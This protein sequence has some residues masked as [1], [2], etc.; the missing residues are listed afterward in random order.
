MSAA[1]SLPLD[2]AFVTEVDPNAWWRLVKQRA[3]GL[4]SQLSVSG[5][6][7]AIAAAVGLGIGYLTNVFV[8]AYRADGF[9]VPSGGVASGQGNLVRG[10]SFWFVF[11]MIVSAV[12]THA[13][14]VGSEQFIDDI[15]NYRVRMLSLFASDGE[16]ATAHALFGFAGATLITRLLGPSL[17]G[18]VGIGLL[19]ALGTVLR[20]M[21]VGAIMI[22]WRWVVR[23]IAPTNPSRSRSESVTVS[24]MGAAAAMALAIIVPGTTIRLV[25]GLAAIVVALVLT[26]R[27]SFG[28]AGLLLFMGATAALTILDVSPVFADDGGWRECGSSAIRW[29]TCSGSD[30]VLWLA[31]FGGSASGFGAGLG[32][33]S[34]TGPPK[35]DKSWGEMTDEERSAFRQSYITRFKET[36]PNATSDQLQRF[37]EGLDSRDATFWE[38]QWEGFK[39]FWGAY[40]DDVSSGK[41]AEGLGGFFYEGWKGFTKAADTAWNE[42]TMLDDTLAELPGVFWDDLASG[43]QAKR[44]GGLLDSIKVAG[45]FYADPD[46]RQALVDKYGPEAAEAVFTKMHELDVALA[47]ADPTEIRQKIGEITG[48]IEFEVLL[49]GMSDKGASETLKF[50]KEAKATGKIDDLVA[51]LKGGKGPDLDVPVRKGPLMP[52]PEIKYPKDLTP[53][54]GKDNWMDVDPFSREP[55]TVQKMEEVFNGLKPGDRI[56]LTPEEAAAW[57]GY[58]KNM[59]LTAQ[60]NSLLWGKQTEAGERVWTEFKRGNADAKF[61]RDNGYVDANGVQQQYSPKSNNIADKSLE[62][63]ELFFVPKDRDF[64]PGEVVTF[65]PT[66]IPEL[67]ETLPDG[68]VVN[69]SLID[70]LQDRATLAE[71]RLTGDKP[72]VGR[73]PVIDEQG[74]QVMGQ[75]W[76]GEDGRWYQRQ[77]VPDTA[78]RH[79][80]DKGYKETWSPESRVAGDNDTFAIG[81]GQALPG[82]QGGVDKAGDILGYSAD[83]KPIHAWDMTEAERL[84]YAASG[85]S[86]PGEGNTPF[87]YTEGVP[88]FDAMKYR[89]TIDKATG[90]GVLLVDAD[91]IFLTRPGTHYSQ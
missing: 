66:R 68:S 37:I 56:R 46:Q 59:L 52:D 21:I 18:A 31:A 12:V 67:G 64:A 20:P 11:S 41:Q 27:V 55:M 23:R 61:L 54:G 89:T 51:A 3:T 82:G 81:G 1:D 91:G 62:Q 48:M 32:A 83:G 7:I 5:P 40:A 29:F 6:R 76:L 28:A 44:L 30:R 13:I 47:N 14:N 16:A 69:Q 90:E 43:D 58:E 75:S 84:Q 72:T 4:W 50:L 74:K 15:R 9:N 26:K 42:L 77:Q 85:G 87:R 80:L 78:G 19:V 34:P 33:A 25:L 2:D 57:G 8:M 71:K 88:G 60:E 35:M 45:E 36:H 49:G 10:V 22:A 79:P 38:N 53:P 24:T 73:G 17:S 70:R 63:S 86:V 65:E 39:N